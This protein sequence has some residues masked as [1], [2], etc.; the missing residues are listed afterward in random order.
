MSQMDNVT[1]GLESKLVDHASRVR[2]EDLPPKVV[3]YCKLLVM[4]SF[5]VTFPGY[6]APGCREVAEL[7]RGWGGSGST[8][9]IYGNET[10]P[11]FAALANSTMMHAMDFDDTLDA[12][13]LH[14]LV[15]VLPAGLATAEYLGGVDGKTLITALVLG[16]DMICRVSLGIR[17]PLSWIRTAT[18]GS[19][20]AAVTAGKILGLD[21]ERLTNA[22]GVAYSQTSGNAQGLIEGRLVKRMQ[23]GF[24]AQ[25][26]VTSAFLSR[27][28]I[29]GSHNFLQGRY[30]FY[31]LYERG[32]YD[33]D[34]VVERLGEHYTILDLSLK[35]YPCCRMTHA[36][37]DAALQLRNVIGASVQDIEEIRVMASKMVTEMVGKTFVIGTD[38]QVDAQ[39]SIPYTV[40][41][42][43]L[44]GDVFLKDFEVAAIMDE[45]VRTLA[46]RVKVT[47][48]PDLPD[49]DIL[50][51]RMTI[52]MKNGQ[53][54]E[55]S[56]NAPLG[57]PAR[58]LTM[59]R[60]KEKFTKC[61]AQS[62][63]DFD[64]GRAN[65]LLSMIEELEQLQDIRRLTKLMQS[66]KAT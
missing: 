40:S 23:P 17:R 47:S 64:D 49:K 21:R 44:R 42:A 35:P 27:A 56:V 26:G 8:V 7:T 4:D 62:K 25:A 65:E 13:A 22:L 10:A 1:R 46:E 28:G 11:P 34:P 5:G 36:S 24:A 61:L 51:A 18:C 48:D 52:R 54:H 38:P 58:P 6:S 14:T 9:L 50:H 53:N 3:E 16:V 59:E 12:S 60:C 55:A 20:G 30:G 32:E 43:L 39:F 31:K 63:V 19:F 15:S 37:I 33:P 29:T 2:F 66:K 45:E 57:N 41:A